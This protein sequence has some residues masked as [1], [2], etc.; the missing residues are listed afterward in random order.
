MLPPVDILPSVV[1][2]ISIELFVV[3]FN[4]PTDNISVVPCV[5]NLVFVPTPISN[6]DPV[7]NVVLVPTSRSNEVAI[8]SF[9]SNPERI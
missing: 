7:L 9:M 4:A 8:D 2:L 3:I 5:V 6:V 1:T